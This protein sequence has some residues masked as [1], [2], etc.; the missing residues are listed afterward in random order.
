[1][2]ILISLPFSASVMPPAS[3]VV[4]RR[5][6]IVHAAARFRQTSVSKRLFH[7]SSPRRDE[8]DEF[9]PPAERHYEHFVRNIFTANLLGSVGHSIAII[10]PRMIYGANRLEDHQL[11]LLL[12]EGKLLSCM[13]QDSPHCMPFVLAK[14]LV[15]SLPNWRISEVFTVIVRATST[16]YPELFGSGNMA[17]LQSQIKHSSKHTAAFVNLGSLRPSQYENLYEA[18]RLPIYDR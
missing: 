12:D 4:I 9:H 18:L 15:E 6:G 1:M 13:R 8:S 5:F 3:L 17:K 11:K 2:R 10:Q 16:T 7:Y 14:A